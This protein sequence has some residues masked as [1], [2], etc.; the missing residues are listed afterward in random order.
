MAKCTP[1]SRPMRRV[2]LGDMRESIKLWPVSIAPATAGQV[3]Y[4]RSYASA[5]TVKAMV[6]T[7]SG[8]EVIDGTAIQRVGTTEFYIRYRAGVDNQVRI[9]YRGEY[10]EV[11]GVDDLDERREFLRLRTTKRGAT[12]NG[13]NA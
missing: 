2:C 13:A 8:S 3:D 7:V 4:T 5:V 11:L 10:Y 9:E 6:K 1:I 12:S